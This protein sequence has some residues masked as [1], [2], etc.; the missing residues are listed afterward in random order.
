MNFRAAADATIQLNSELN[1][2][3]AIRRTWGLDTATVAPL[4]MTAK[5]L[6]HIIHVDEPN[7]GPKAAATIGVSRVRRNCVLSLPSNM[8]MP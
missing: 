8:P 4:C 3:V 6:M 7:D 1:L 5:S 2:P